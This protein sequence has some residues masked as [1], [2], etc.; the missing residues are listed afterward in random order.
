MPSFISICLRE[1]LRLIKPLLNKF[2]IK[3]A[4]E[5]QDKLGEIGAKSAGSKVCFEPF[6]INGIEAC[7]AQTDSPKPGR[8]ILYLHG[9]AYVSGNIMYAR[10][11]ASV[12]AVETNQRV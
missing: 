10:G 8:V 9:G 7:F 12:L 11:F 4:R 5:L 1:E 6:T 3:T 2:S